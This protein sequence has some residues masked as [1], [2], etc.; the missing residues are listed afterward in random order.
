MIY[1]CLD[2]YLD[3]SRLTAI[4]ADIREFTFNSLYRLHF[5]GLAAPYHHPVDHFARGEPG[6]STEA[7]RALA[8]ALAE[9]KAGPRRQDPAM[10]SYNGGMLDLRDVVLI[11][12]VRHTEDSRYGNGRRRD[13]KMTA[14]TYRYSVLVAGVA[15]ITFEY[16]DTTGTPPPELFRDHGRLLGAWTGYHFRP[17]QGAA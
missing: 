13:S 12:D 3:L 11:E 15:P 7:M 8:V 14:H 17:E 16:R 4:D 2:I 10:I 5:D 6:R 1:Q 9:R